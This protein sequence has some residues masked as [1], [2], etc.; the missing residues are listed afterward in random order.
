MEE[1]Q[2]PNKNLSLFERIKQNILKKNKD[3]AQEETE[4]E[5][6][7][8]NVEDTSDII[9]GRGVVSISTD[10]LLFSIWK[11][12]KDAYD[13]KA[14]IEEQNV[15]ETMEELEELELVLEAPGTQEIPMSDEEIEMEKQRAAVQLMMKSKSY[16]QLIQPKENG[17]VPNLDAYM[18]IHVA[19][20]HMAAWAFV[21][22]PSGQGMPLKKSQVYMALQEYSVSAGINEKAID[23]LVEEQPYFKLVPIAYGTPMVPGTDG[24]IREM[25]KREVEKTFAVNERGDVDYRV[26]NYIQS[27]HTGDVIC[28]TVPPIEGKDGLD[29]LGTVIPKKEGQPAK[30]LA[31]QNTTLNEDKTQIIASMDG[32]LVFESG[33]FH[34]K[35]LFYVKG[36]VDLSVGN[37]D[38]LGDVHI[39]GDVRDDFV[40]RATGT[41]TVDGLVEGAIIEAGK[42]VIIAKG[43][44]GDEKAVIKAGGNVQTEYIENC[45]IYAGDT[46]QAGSII[47][48]Y[49]HS[50]NCIVVRVGRGTI[51]GGKMVAANLIDAKIIGCRA[52]RMTELIVGELPYT[53]NKKEELAESLEKIQKEKKEIEHMAGN[54]SHAIVETDP[55]KLQKAAN[56]RLRQSVLTMQEAH[57]K[58]QLEQFEDKSTEV[59]NCKIVGDTVYPVTK[60]RIHD[61]TCTVTEKTMSCRIH[62]SENEIK[63]I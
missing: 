62:I 22:P 35:P 36:D 23:Y 31:G 3:S 27:V 14:D 38:F 11:E 21:F 56:L 19:Q 47:S 58:K 43:I 50:D 4:E 63:L 9:S 34:V 41:V 40:V 26:Q 2:E 53:E 16:H 39:E 15:E 18:V 30:L 29:V 54:I 48:S 1:R 57:L 25:F 52:E 55:A 44:L 42:D 20:R 6:V 61:Y 5:I 49:V 32:H 33:K 51:I 59:V 17:E 28:E 7:S 8:E 46:V 60:V 45:I 10:S 24:T 37:I 12:W 13:S